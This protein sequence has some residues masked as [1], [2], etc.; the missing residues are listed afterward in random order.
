MA[1]VGCFPKLAPEPASNGGLPGDD[2]GGV[3]GSL[4]ERSF[5]DDATLP[6]GNV[7]LPDGQLLAPLP[8]CTAQ[9][10]ECVRVL[11]G[12]ADVAKIAC[13]GVYFVGDMTL[14]LERAT[15]TGEF[16][17]IQ[18]Q[19]TDTPGLG[20]TLEDSTPPPVEVTT[21]R[22]CIEDSTGIRC[23]APFSIDGLPPDCGCE[24]YSC[25]STLVC[26]AKIYD[27]CGG[28]ITCGACS[29]GSACN[30]AHSCCPAGLEG[31]VNG[32]CVCAPPGPCGAFLTWDTE[33]CTCVN[34]Y[35]G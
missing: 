2:G 32:G 26:N 18:T 29:N 20:L 4:V 23:G 34:N 19:T 25:A 14:L 35:G 24:G 16:D 10:T 15:A 6:D 33:T 5:P 13:S 28:Y 31:S 8:T 21:Y 11:Y 27:G 9:I 30:A 22:V 12:W 1:V 17:V 7:E 3:D